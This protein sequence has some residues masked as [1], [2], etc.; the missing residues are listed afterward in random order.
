VAESVAS[1][2]ATRSVTIESMWMRLANKS[3]PSSSTRVRLTT[4]PCS[5]WVFVVEVTDLAVNSGGKVAA[6]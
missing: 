4:R 3:T 1:L 2:V 6:P 5:R